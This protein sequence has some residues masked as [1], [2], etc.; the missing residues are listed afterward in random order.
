M[1]VLWWGHHLPFSK[2][3]QGVIDL[4]SD[5][6]KV[7]QRLLHT[8]LSLGKVF[9]YSHSRLIRSRGCLCSSST[10]RLVLASS[11]DSGSVSS[12]CHY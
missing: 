9:C 12:I 3:S 5:L 6:L 4:V 8:I 1:F 7:H 10:L 11:G 2:S